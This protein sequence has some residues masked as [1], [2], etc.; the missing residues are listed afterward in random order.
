MENQ[1]K[2]IVTVLLETIVSNIYLVRGK[3]VMLDSDLA[4]LYQVPVKVLTQS[5][6]R[7]IN[8]FPSDFMFQIALNETVAL[9]SQIVTLKRGEHRKYLPYVSKIFRVLR[10]LVKEEKSLKRKS[11]LRPISKI[12]K[13]L[14]EKTKRQNKISR[15]VG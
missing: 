10:Y 11:D 14:N 7:N 2:Q 1:N 12:T 8:R 4:D 15:R 13:Q 9:R 5:V 3:K 6:K